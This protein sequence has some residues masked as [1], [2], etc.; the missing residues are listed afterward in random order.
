MPDR[1]KGMPV[2]LQQLTAVLA[3]AVCGCGAPAVREVG[4]GLESMTK[5]QEDAYMAETLSAD[6]PP[7]NS[8]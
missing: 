4:T 5:Q 7:E 8:R 2:T 3:L 1:H 6:A